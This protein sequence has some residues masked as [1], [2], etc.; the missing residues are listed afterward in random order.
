MRYATT[1]AQVQ[2]IL[3]S[4]ADDWRDTLITTVDVIYSRFEADALQ[5]ERHAGCRNKLKIV[6]QKELTK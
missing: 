4:D 1:T 3:R 5:R 2:R 6:K